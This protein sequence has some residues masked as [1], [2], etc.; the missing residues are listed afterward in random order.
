[1]G[2]VYNVAVGERTSLNELYA[3]LRDLI[4][5]RHPR[6]RIPAP[7]YAPF[8][9]GDVR[10]SEADIGKARR[11]L[12]YQ[13]VWNVRNGLAQALPWYEKSAQ[14]AADDIEDLPNVRRAI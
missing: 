7:E 14:F 4:A 2:Q 9:Q 13:P 5:E 12:G 10:H 11:L 6:L 8:R 1:L 3:V